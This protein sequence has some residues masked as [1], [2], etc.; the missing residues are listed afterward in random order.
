MFKRGTDIRLNDRHGSLCY[1]SCLKGSLC[2]TNC[3]KGS[4]LFSLHTE[5]YSLERTDISYRLDIQAEIIVPLTPSNHS[6][7]KSH[8]TEIKGIRFICL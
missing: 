6:H 3:L 8:L 7:I 5:S 2:Y 4:E 1:T